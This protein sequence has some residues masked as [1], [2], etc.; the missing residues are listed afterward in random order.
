MLA[1][2][3][4]AVTDV[5]TGQQRQRA[6][7]DDRLARGVGHMPCRK[8]LI[9]SVPLLLGRRCRST[10]ASARHPDDGAGPFP[11]VMMSGPR[12]TA[13]ATTSRSS[14]P[15]TAE[16]AASSHRTMALS[17]SRSDRSRCGMHAA[18]PS[19]GPG[20]DD[21][22]LDAPFLPAASRRCSQACCVVRHPSSFAERERPPAT[23]SVDSRPS[24]DRCATGDRRL[25]ARSSVA[26]PR[27]ASAGPARH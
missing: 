18:T 7:L 20:G 27:R 12:A 25:S 14:L 6:E 2:L 5:V 21:A 10:P 13:A 1:R 16:S 11:L 26:A 24:A 19:S 22:L 23:S 9:A 17:T 8:L 15:W 3:C 4:E